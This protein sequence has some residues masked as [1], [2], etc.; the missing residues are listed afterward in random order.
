LVVGRGAGHHLQQVG[1]ILDNLV[2][3][4]DQVMG[5]RRILGIQDK[6]APGPLAKP[7]DEPVIPGA[8]KQ[9]L[10]PIQG[11]F[12]SAALALARLRPFV[13]HRRRKLQISRHFLG[14][15]LVEYLPQ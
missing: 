3:G 2:G 13:N 12:N 6:K 14:I 1:K 11:V 9:R 8:G 15:L 5:M 7:L 4:R 10:H